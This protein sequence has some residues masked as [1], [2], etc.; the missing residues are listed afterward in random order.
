MSLDNLRNPHK[1]FVDNIPKTMSKTELSN[2][3]SKYGEIDDII[4]I[5]KEKRQFGFAYINYTLSKDAEACSNAKEIDIGEA[6]KLNVIFARPK[7]S[8]K[9]LANIPTVLKDYIKIVQKG[10]REYNPKDFNDIEQQFEDEMTSKKTT[11]TKDNSDNANN[12]Q[13]LPQTAPKNGNMIKNNRLLKPQPNFIAVPMQAY[14]KQ[15]QFAQVQRGQQKEMYAQQNG[16]YNQSVYQAQPQMRSQVATNYQQQQQA[17]APNQMNVSQQGYY[18][19]KQTQACY[20]AYA[21]QQQRTYGGYNHNGDYDYQQQYAGYNDQQSYYDD[22]YYNS[23]SQDSYS[24]Q[25][26]AQYKEYQQ[27]QQQAQYSETSKVYSA[28][29]S[30]YGS[31][32][33]SYEAE[34]ARQQHGEFC[35]CMNCFMSSSEFQEQKQKWSTEKRQSG[36]YNVPMARNNEYTFDAV[37]NDDNQH[38]GYPAQY[39][40]YAYNQQSEWQNYNYSQC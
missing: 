22:Y 23:Q 12:G 13:V 38:Y 5:V 31:N 16:Y 32:K 3:F 15:Q 7:F 17:Y 39:Q 8:K 28:Y 14:Q 40:N 27:S 4:L 10:L 18:N 9:M 21:P 30:N 29:G 20:D 2:K 24:R 26:Q 36:S 33:G 19:Q 34:P 25:Q 35:D 6:E 11:S 1:I 37:L